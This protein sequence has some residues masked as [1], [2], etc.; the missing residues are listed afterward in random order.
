MQHFQP[1]ILDYVTTGCGT[2]ECLRIL[3]DVELTNQWLVAVWI[4]G[5]VW[6]TLG[7]IDKGL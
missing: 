3:N 4:H 7:R 2:H 6:R 5:M 1:A